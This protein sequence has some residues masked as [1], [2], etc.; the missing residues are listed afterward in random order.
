MCTAITY[1]TENLYFG[2]TLDLECSFLEKVIITPRNYKFVFNNN[3]STASHYAMIGIGIT[4]NNYPLYYDAVNEKGLC[5]AGL[6]FPGNAVYNTAKNGYI[7]LASYEFIPYLLSVCGSV[8]EAIDQINKIN[9]TSSAFSQELQPTPLHWIIADKYKSITVEPLSDGLKIYDNFVGVL[10]NNPTFDYQ[11][12]SLNN[13]QNVSPSELE[14]KFADSIK[15]TK[16]SRGLAGIGLPGDLSSNSRFIRACFTL[17]NSVSPDVDNGDV[18]QFFH[19]LE[20]VSQTRGSVR[21]EDGKL[22]QTVY[23]SCCDTKNLI[24]Y[25]TTYCNRQINAVELLNENIDGE[26]IREYSIEMNQNIKYIN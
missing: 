22:E 19:I 17:L 6:N 20:A 13:Y 9:I 5:I 26:S 11:I 8:E 23:T 2:R 1:K 16:Y 15:L 4:Q 7:N 18:T 12:F 24:Y 25:F 3:F 14:G 21:L 10:T